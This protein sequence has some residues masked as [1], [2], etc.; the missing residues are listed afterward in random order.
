M[1]AASKQAPVKQAR[2]MK[3][4]FSLTLVYLSRG[5]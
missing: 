2:V 1:I 3:A 5:S 4:V